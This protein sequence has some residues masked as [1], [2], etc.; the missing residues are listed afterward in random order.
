MSSPPA[1]HASRNMSACSLQA[2]SH[3]GCRL[4]VASRANTSRPRT[5]GLGDVLPRSARNL[6]RLDC[7]P[8]VGELSVHA[9]TEALRSIV[10]LTLHAWWDLWTGGTSTI[11]YARD[12]WTNL[13]GVPGEVPR[14]HPG[15]TIQPDQLPN[16][17]RPS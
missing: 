3:A 1:A 7:G 10:I 4:A 17:N 6:S 15:P 9:V 2:V 14:V 5:P 12:A 11:S 8:V 16:F 13:E